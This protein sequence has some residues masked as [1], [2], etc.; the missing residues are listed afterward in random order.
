MLRSKYSVWIARL[1][2]ATLFVLGLQPNAI[3]QS[4]EETAY[5]LQPLVASAQEGAEAGQSYVGLNPAQGLRIVFTPQALDI[6]AQPGGDQGWHLGWQVEDYTREGAAVASRAATASI[7]EGNSIQYQRDGLSEWYVN[8][9]KGLKQGF[10]LHQ[11]PSGPTAE[12]LLQVRLQ[13]HGDLSPV[14]SRDGQAIDF[15]AANGAALLRYDA[16]HV[17]DAQQTT[18]PA[19]FSLT[20]NGIA[21]N[22]DDSSA[23]YPITI[24][25]LLTSYE[26]KRTAT[27]AAADDFLGHDVNV[28]QGIA[29]VGV[30]GDDNEKGADAGVVY[31]FDYNLGGTG[32]WGQR[33]RLIAND[34]AA[35]DNF[36][37]DVYVTLG[38]TVSVGAPGVG[39]NVGAAY[40]YAKDQGGPNAWGQIAKVTAGDGAAND[41]FGSAVSV[42]HHT[43][44]VGAPGDGGGSGSVYV[45]EQNPTDPTV[46]NQTKKLTDGAANSAFGT[47]VVISNDILV[48]GAPGDAGSSGTIF[49]YERNL[50]GPN[51]WGMLGSGRKAADAHNGDRFGTSLN[52]S[53]ERIV[54]GA[55][56]NN[57]KGAN[58][59]AAYIY[60]RN[61]DGPDAWGPRPKITAP[62]GAAGDEFGR[63][64][65][66]GGNIAIVGAP[67]DDD[68]GD[69]S[70]SAYL[71]FFRKTGEGAWGNMI[72]VNAADGA[73]GDQFGTSVDQRS[74]R[75]VIGA[76]MEDDAGSNAGAVYF[77][78]T[79]FDL[80]TLQ[81]AN[82]V[83]PNDPSTNWNY[84]VDGILTHEES[85][86]GD[87][88]TAPAF[89]FP[90]TYTVTESAGVGTDLSDYTTTW[91]CTTDGT[92]SATGTGTTLNV[93]VG[94]RENVV[95]NFT[96]QLP[97]TVTIQ[98]ETNPDGSPDDFSFINDIEAPN[99]FTLKDGETRTFSNVA[100]G[101][102]QVTETLPANWRLSSIVCPDVDGGSSTSGT[103]ATIDLDAGE[104][105]HCTFTNKVK[106]GISVIKSA[107]ATS[108]S[109]GQSV[110]Y[111]YT[112]IND[113]ADAL[114]GVVAVDDKLGPVTLG[115]TTLAPDGETTG[116]LTYVI[117]ATDL[118]GPLVNTVVVTGTPPAA[119]VVTDSSSW[120]INIVG[121]A[122]IELTVTANPTTAA[123]DDSITYSYR[124]TNTGSTLLTNV[125]VD[126]NRLGPVTLVD[127]SLQPGESTNGT[128]V[129]LVKEGDL[130]GPLTD[131]VSAGGTSPLGVEV[132][133]SASVSVALTASVE[134]AAINVT[135]SANVTTAKVGDIITYTVEVE[136]SG[137]STLTGVA[138]TS[139]RLGVISLAETTLAPG[140]STTGTKAYTVV[141]GD[142]PGP[143]TDTVTA[144]GTPP[145][146]DPVEAQATASVTLTDSES[147]ESLK[148]PLIWR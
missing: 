135:M 54:V 124:V 39:N 25:P 27:D 128:H 23:V 104:S 86:T 8:D 18:L 46:W 114:S 51:A 87:S 133:D 38:V 73:A 58:A 129:Y 21:I 101:T 37:K 118:P 19:F 22:V 148:L 15:V 30:Y 20:Q 35:G 90:G 100:P 50:G 42:Q 108:A 12:V 65:G 33:A 97:G 146:G 117:Q 103:T 143:L 7:V 10:T 59:G 145:A 28:S 53:T 111:T 34:G 6:S 75:I 56:G 102:Y 76:P 1:I 63:S 74:G 70:G 13:V 144:T 130:P 82:N 71:V 47:A 107:S 24:D 57:E 84:T 134:E 115:T 26:K 121:D 67:L 136:N 112:V 119:P 78:E 77:Y 120:S 131:N 62:D 11:P 89:L 3:A 66:I 139:N 9:A 80:G 123:V 72:K 31:L 16:L 88:Q 83:E 126:N 44:V 48:V 55:P 36:G 94:L 141:A 4:S 2:I 142:L 85:T 92:P 69:A 98:K 29:I 61:L 32:N 49:I 127:T 132:E 99:A 109:V 43:L 125:H 81:I 68:N 95:C 40:L 137:A 52:I 79:P 64:V 138:A 93:F 140:A 91:S 60:E 96:H 17:F 14:L 122:S 116:T 147:Q 106:D 105:A 5:T 110:T 113:S 45:Y 41:G